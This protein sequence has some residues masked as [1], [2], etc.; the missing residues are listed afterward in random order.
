MCESAASP[1]Q[2]VHDEFVEITFGAGPAARPAFINP[3]VASLT[4]SV[5]DV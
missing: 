2:Y 4:G 3:P 5:L 1:R